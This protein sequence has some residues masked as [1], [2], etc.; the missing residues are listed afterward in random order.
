MP[1]NLKTFALLLILAF[2]IACSGSPEKKDQS[3]TDSGPIPRYLELI[4]AKSPIVFGALDPVPEPIALEQYAFLDQY[5]G[6]LLEP[7]PPAAELDYMG[8]EERFLV[9][10][11]REMN[12]NLDEEG[13][14]RL[15]LSTSPRFVV[16]TVGPFPVFRAEIGDAKKFN[17]MLDRVEKASGLT[18]ERQTMEGVEYR[19]HQDGEVNVALAV[20]GNEVVVT[21]TEPDASPIV[22]PYALGVKKPQ[23]SLADDNVLE[24][25]AG[26]YGIKRHGVGFVNV[27]EFVGMAT[28]G[29]DALNAAAWTV[30][31]T[32]EE[33]A[34][35]AC[36][37][38]ASEYAAAM[39]LVAFGLESITTERLSI[40]M[41]AEFSNDIPARLKAAKRSIPGWDASP[42]EMSSESPLSIGLGFAV[43]EI[44]AIA[45]DELRETRDR[46]FEC[47]EL[48]NVPKQASE[49]L[50]MSQLIPPVVGDLEG[51]RVEFGGITQPETQPSMPSA[52]PQFNL[53]GVVQAPDPQSLFSALKAF[54]PP[55]I[56]AIELEPDGEPVAMT[57]PDGSGQTPVDALKF[58][59]TKRALGFTTSDSLLQTAQSVARSE[60]SESPM[61]AASFNVRE[62]MMNFMMGAAG[63]PA[64]VDSNSV[65]ISVDPTDEAIVTDVSIPL[66]LVMST[67]K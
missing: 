27:V 46:A 17:E 24:D 15:G 65:Y 32:N 25:L 26:K 49:M 52:S 13:L 33:P 41:A 5:L 48:Q 38:E 39:P 43:S 14:A 54:A 58:F 11:A 18:W 47:P 21:V 29:G 55:E 57:L 64:E 31:S 35:P 2:S 53:W 45:R 7:L 63:A 56:Q 60:A 42:V 30:V 61:I 34:L 10:F 8:P 23:A 28:G 9:E 51:A 19:S 3:L 20:I 67:A 1:S 22:L 12:G 37:K 40:K 16:Y 36:Q 59:M 6:S 50:A 44:L 62:L 66:E 4:P